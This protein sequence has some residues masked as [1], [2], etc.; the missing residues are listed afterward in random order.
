MEVGL[1]NQ[2]KIIKQRIALKKRVE[3]SWQEESVK[4]Y[5]N[6]I[7]IRLIPKRS[8]QTNINSNT[9]LKVCLP[10][11]FNS[12]IMTQERENQYRVFVFVFVAS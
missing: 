6:Q 4:E 11:Q 7:C 8:V 2:K 1:R 12:R 9:W 3:E 5:K 10:I